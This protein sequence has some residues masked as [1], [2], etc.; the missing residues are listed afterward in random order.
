M[1]RCEAWQERPQKATLCWLLLV[2]CAALSC[3]FALANMLP[4]VCLDCE[5]IDLF[6]W[7]AGS[8]CWLADESFAF[9]FADN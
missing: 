3:V 8:P 5:L 7:L 2:C 6:G 9:F 4:R 1:E